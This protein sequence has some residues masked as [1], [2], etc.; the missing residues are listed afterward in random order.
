[1]SVPRSLYTQICDLREIATEE[2]TIEELK[3]AGY[4]RKEIVAKFKQIKMDRNSFDKGLDRNQ[5]ICYFK[6][7][8]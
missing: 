5:M 2:E 7:A 1:M 8:S 3:K 4:K 6:V